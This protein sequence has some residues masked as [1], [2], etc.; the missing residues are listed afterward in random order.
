MSR[1][2]YVW[3]LDSCKHSFF[4][5]WHAWWT[6]VIPILAGRLGCW[7]YLKWGS[8]LAS[9]MNVTEIQK[10]TNPTY[11]TCAFMNPPVIILM[12]PFSSWVDLSRIINDCSTMT[13]CICCSSNCQQVSNHINWL[14]FFVFFVSQSIIKLALQ[15]L[16]ACSCRCSSSTALTRHNVELRLRLLSQIRMCREG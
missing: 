5:S 2:S 1:F 16:S 8:Q 15:Q 10:Y 12:L 9:N 13:K 7:W 6:V 4:G 14:S 11:P 3:Q